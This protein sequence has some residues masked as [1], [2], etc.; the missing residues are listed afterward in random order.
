MK[1]ENNTFKTLYRNKTYSQEFQ[2]YCEIKQ[3]SNSR[4]DEGFF[5]V[6]LLN[7][8]SAEQENFFKEAVDPQGNKLFPQTESLLKNI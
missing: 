5:W 3:E 1:T 4:V 8:P 6:D 2:N 7:M